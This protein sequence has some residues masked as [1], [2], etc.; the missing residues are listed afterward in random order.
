MMDKSELISYTT[1]SLSVFLLVISGYH[2]AF[3]S[4]G[5]FLIFFILGC[6]CYYLFVKNEVRG[7]YD[8]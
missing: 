2:L 3:Y 4:W 6:F 7:V 5:L 8:G 1:L